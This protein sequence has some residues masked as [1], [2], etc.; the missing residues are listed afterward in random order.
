MAGKLHDGFSK[1]ICQEG[2]A[3]LVTN[4]VLAFLVFGISVATIGPALPWLTQHWHVRLDDGGVL[5]TLLFT[6]S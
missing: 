2:R 3:A 5:F 4:T 6:G 1:A